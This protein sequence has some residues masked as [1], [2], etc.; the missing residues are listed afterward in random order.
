MSLLIER[1]P[2][3]I[4]GLGRVKTYEMLTLMRAGKYEQAQ[5]L[6]ESK[7]VLTDVREGEVLITDLWFELMSRIR[8]GDASEE[9][10]A[11]VNEKLK[12]PQNIDFRMN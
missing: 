3:A 6:L 9:H 8:F 4:R 5:E 11:W 1:L 10:L 12:P 2:Q 7:I